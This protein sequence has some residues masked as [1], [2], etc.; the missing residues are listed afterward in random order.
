MAC[1]IGIDVGGT[2]TDA[3]VVK[4]RE[5]LAWTKVTTTKDVTTGVLKAIHGV[6]AKLKPQGLTTFLTLNKL[7]R[8]KTSTNKFGNYSFCQLYC[9][10]KP[11][12]G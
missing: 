12:I 4:N 8:V 6:L 3:V 7:Y 10:K 9:S 5:I 1:V 11:R 2:N